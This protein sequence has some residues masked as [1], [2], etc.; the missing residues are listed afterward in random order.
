MLELAGWW[1]VIDGSSKVPAAHSSPVYFWTPK[2]HCLCRYLPVK[3]FS[4][5]AV[6][7]IRD[8]YRIPKFVPGKTNELKRRNR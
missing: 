3:V 2:A 4:G 8:G 1:K 5:N 6:L 7:Y